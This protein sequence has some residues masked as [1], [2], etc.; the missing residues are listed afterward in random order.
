MAKKEKTDNGTPSASQQTDAS[1][2]KLLSAVGEDDGR[3]FVVPSS[4]SKGKSAQVQFRAQPGHMRQAEIL[5]QSRAFPWYRTLSDMLR[6]A[7]L[8]HIIYLES[9]EPNP[10]SMLWKL[11]A[12]DEVLKDQEI[13]SAFDKTFSVLDESIRRHMNAG[14]EDRARKL[15]YAMWG[16]IQSASGDDGLKK[17]YSSRMQKQYG[18]LLPKEGPLSFADMDDTE[19]NAE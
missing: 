6:H 17:S 9:L 2:D 12:M 1:I 13:D 11:I 16:I 8:R 19:E 5:L 4:D 10:D 7:L 15:I 14:D 18:H 3:Q